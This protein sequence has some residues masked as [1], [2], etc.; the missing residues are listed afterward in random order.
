LSLKAWI[1]TACLLLMACPAEATVG[2][3]RT[4]GFVSHGIINL[5]FA[6][7][8]GLVVLTDSMVTVGEK[9]LT[10]PAQKLFRLDDYTVCTVA[11]FLAADAPV[12]EMY[13]STSAIIREYSRQLAQQQL[14]GNPPKS[15]AA[16]LRE[17]E[18]LFNV[19]LSSIAALRVASGRSFAPAEYAMQLI[20]TGYDTDGFPKIEKST[21]RTAFVNGI[22]ET[23]ADE[24]DI[25]NVDETLVHQS[26]GMP[27]V[28]EELL[29]N[30]SAANQDSILTEFAESI[31]KDPILAEYAESIKKD[32]GRSLTIEQMQALAKDLALYSAK[33]HPEVG[34]ANQ[35]AVLENGRIASLAQQPFPEPPQNL[36]F[37]LFENFG[38]SGDHAASIGG[39]M[40]CV[41]CNFGH[42]HWN[43]DGNYFLTTNF[44]DT[45]LTYDGGLTYFDKT[46][47]VVH[48]V[49]VIGPHAR[50]HTPTVQHL[51]RDFSWVRIEYPGRK[52]LA[53][54]A[55]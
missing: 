53:Q 49:L 50:L 48:S 55:S 4:N 43:L 22:F 41:R 34:G 23:S 33:R 15:I 5:V 37:G 18:F 26:G 1:F 32:H 2:K 40:L 28:A 42:L 8:N 31:R 51:I 35:V 12:K 30:P 38:V 6:N 9:Q 46:N 3:S 27:D 54:R 25:T 13:A 21:L 20:V 7:V 16:K 44:T 29:K 19:R 45:I 52:P 17:L 47:Q 36:H 14:S 11:G 24:A 39:S 10:E